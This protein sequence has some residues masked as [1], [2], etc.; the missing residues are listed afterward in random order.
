MGIFKSIKGVFSDNNVVVINGKDEEA[1]K[2]WL[3]QRLAT[4]L[5][6]DASVI[7]PS[8]PFEEYG[9]D[10]L[11]AVRVTSELEKVVELRLSP[12]LLFEN[13]CIND[14]ARVIAGSDQ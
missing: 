1:V 4:Q 9:L 6:K 5:K 11:F 7:D 2:A 8:T 14:V 10:S 3:I 13:T 12:A